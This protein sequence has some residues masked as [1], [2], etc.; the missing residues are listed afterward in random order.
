MF[1]MMGS[2]LSVTTINK[3]RACILFAIGVCVIC[4]LLLRYSPVL[5][6][7][8]VRNQIVAT[9]MNTASHQHIAHIVAAP[10]EIET[11]IGNMFMGSDERSETEEI[12]TTG[13]SANTDGFDL[14][15][16]GIYIRDIFGIGFS[17]KL[18]LVLDPSRIII[19]TAAVPG[20]EPATVQS[21]VESYG[22]IAG[23]NG[24]WYAGYAPTGFVIAGNTRVFPPSE[25]NDQVNIV[26]FTEDNVLVMGAYNEQEAH[27]ARIR[28]CLSCD[29]ILIVNGS[30]LITT[31][32]GGWGIAPRTAIAQRKD[33]AVLLLTLDGRQSHSIGATLIQVQDVLM[34]NYAHNAIG[35]DGGCSTAMYYRGGYLNKPSLGFERDIPT[36]FLVR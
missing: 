11:I 21:M 10:T 18:M 7:N 28:D 5:P 30:P 25:H 1:L 20:E 2:G 16:E 23:I 34:D 6:F 24:G 3:W 36:A 26:G 12:E 8:Y 9:S 31:G 32:D 29:P 15:E 22:A 13:I 17:G 4:F 14:L 33:G 19:G 35:L 27:G